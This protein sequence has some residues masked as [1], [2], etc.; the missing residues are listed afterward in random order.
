MYKSPM[1]ALKHGDYKQV[2]TT[3]QNLLTS[4]KP[5]LEMILEWTAFLVYTAWNLANNRT[6]SIQEDV[7]AG[8]GVA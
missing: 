4:K 5:R 3:A 2:T 1:T 7:K 8:C 6:P